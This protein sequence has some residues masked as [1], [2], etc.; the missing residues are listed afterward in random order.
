MS[1]RDKV[2]LFAVLLLGI[3]VGGYKLLIEP[4]QIRTTELEALLESKED[5]QR[6]LQLELAIIPTIL[7][8][9]EESKQILEEEVG[10]YGEYLFDEDADD[11][12]TRLLNDNNLW[13]LDL[14]IDTVFGE[15]VKSGGITDLTS[16]K[17]KIN[18]A[19]S[20][21]DTLNFYGD[22][23]DRTDILLNGFTF[24][25]RSI[26]SIQTDYRSSISGLIATE[27]EDFKVEVMGEISFSVLTNNYVPPVD[28]NAEASDEEET[29]GGNEEATA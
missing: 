26:E 9:V 15:V 10:K 8:S 17:F 5:E 13:M 25:E 1:Q 24:S 2:I 21:E 29:V 7:A 20:L 6:Q 14:D 4:E 18:F 3:V 22:I 16:R 11:Y 12:A 23:K 27:L 28:E 19:G